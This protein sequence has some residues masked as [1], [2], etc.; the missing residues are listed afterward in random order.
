[1]FLMGT[2]FAGDSGSLQGEVREVGECY[3]A[4]PGAAECGSGYQPES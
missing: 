1:M 2:M 3:T 4:D